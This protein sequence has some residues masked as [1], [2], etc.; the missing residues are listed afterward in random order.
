[1]EFVRTPDERFTNILDWPYEPIYTNINANDGTNTVLRV[2][3]YEAGP[4]DAKE[5]IL[6]MHGEPSWSFLYRKMMKVFVS[7]GHRVIA[8]DLIGFGRSDKPTQ[9]SDYT[10]ERHVDW[11]NQWFNAHQFSGLTLMCQDWGGLVGLRLVTA[12]VQA[13]D[14]VVVSNTGLPMYGKEPTEA[15]RAWQ[16]FSR[17]VP[18]FDVGKM[19]NAGCAVKLSPEEIAAYDAPFPDESFKA[20]ARIFPSL[21]PDGENDPSNI[22]NKKAW[23]ILS[24]WKKPFLC[25]FSDGDPITAGGDRAFTRS[26]P[27]C[28]GQAHTTI[29][30]GGHFLQEDKGEEL[31]GVINDFMAATPK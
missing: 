19:V 17:E 11:M 16:K 7:A 13:F 26:V 25:A 22:A 24:A 18:V 5:T 27:G 15:F 31:A 29:V 20:G 4:S 9:I 2:A 12:N 30:G 14:R 23:E 3:H 10:Y 1:M 6:M 28:E 21:Y 8:P